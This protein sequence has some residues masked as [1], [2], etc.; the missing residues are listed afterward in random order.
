M[1]TSEA[2]ELRILPAGDR[3]LLLAPGD[4]RGSR[5]AGRPV[6][7]RR[8]RRD[9][10]LPPGSRDG[11]GHPRGRR[12][13]RDR[14]A[15]PAAATDCG[16]ATTRSGPEDTGD[17]VIIPVRYDGADL[18]DVARLLDI[19]VEEVV[20]RHTGRVWRCRFIGFTAGFG[21]LASPDAG[22][23][24]PRRQQSRTSVP[25]GRRRPRRRLQR[26][27]PAPG[28]GRVAAHR[29][30]RGADVGPR[31]PAAGTAFTRHPG[32]VR[33]GGPLMTTAV[34][35]VVAP[36]PNATIQ[37]LGRPGWFSAGVGVS[38]AADTVSLRLANRLVGNT[39]TRRGSSVCSAGCTCWPWRR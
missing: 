19:S 8:S 9:A 33:G 35:R 36:G 37:D 30:H 34:L 23:S 17:E 16:H 13:R 12:R 11:A 3:A 25:A 20:A 38:G 15:R 26:R 28:T 4:R 22:L 32:P 29:L 21:Y 31:P 39:T 7:R 6:A 18:D 1:S 14:R 27:L 2:S 10:G 24:V 5:R